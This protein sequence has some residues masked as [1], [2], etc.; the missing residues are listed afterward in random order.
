MCYGNVHSQEIVN[1]NLTHVL[2]NGRQSLFKPCGSLSVEIQDPVFIKTRNDD[3]VSMLIQD[4]QFL[5]VMDEQF[6][7][8]DDDKW[9]A[10]L[11]LKSNRPR[12]PNNKI[13]A[14]HR[15]KTLE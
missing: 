3:K 10:P 8:S 7:R 4:R 14:L 5:K 15:A 9:V 6:C 13:Q 1:V 2:D 11:P 12:L